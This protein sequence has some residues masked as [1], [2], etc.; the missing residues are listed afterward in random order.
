MAEVTSET[1]EEIY[2]L[3]FVHTGDDGVTFW[4]AESTGHEATDIARGEYLA[5][6]AIETAR[7][8]NLPELLAFVLRDITRAG[9]FSGLEAGF[10]TI[11]ASA[12]RA[13][14]MN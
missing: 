11:V 14:S 7:R 10:L 13:G 8:L 5:I 6:L 4:G 1:A 9:K 2:R 12:A 3:P